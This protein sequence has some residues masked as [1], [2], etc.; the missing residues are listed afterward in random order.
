MK[1]AIWHTTLDVEDSDLHP[2][3]GLPCWVHR[4]GRSDVS[5]WGPLTGYMIHL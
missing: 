4:A 3:S 5:W 1:C 2:K